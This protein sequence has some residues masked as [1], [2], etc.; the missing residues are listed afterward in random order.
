[1][2]ALDVLTSE[3]RK[4]IIHR[5]TRA[6]AEKLQREDVVAL[7]SFAYLDATLHRTNNKNLGPEALRQA[8][9]INQD[10]LVELLGKIQEKRGFEWMGTVTEILRE[11]GVPEPTQD[12]VT[13]IA[14]MLVAEA[15]A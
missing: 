5:I 1:M 6:V 14:L 15:V 9:G 13:S 11:E 3:R 12:E 4:L 7:Y 10:M 8:V 2:N